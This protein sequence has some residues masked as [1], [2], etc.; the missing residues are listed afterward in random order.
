MNQNVV[1]KQEKK[2]ESP[3]KYQCLKLYAKIQ[4][5]EDI[6]VYMESCFAINK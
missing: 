5:N 6:L 2:Q 1:A 4:Q 3:Q